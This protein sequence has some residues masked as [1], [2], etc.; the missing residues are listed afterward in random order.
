M[1]FE[2]AL[3]LIME[4]T[5]LQLTNIQLANLGMVLKEMTQG[6]L[7]SRVTKSN[8]VQKISRVTPLSY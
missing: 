4:D 2:K 1:K 8:A 6:G 7:E 5:L 3:I